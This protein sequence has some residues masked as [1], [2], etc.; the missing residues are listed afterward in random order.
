MRS[1]TATDGAA[2]VP[3]WGVPAPSIAGRRGCRSLS[4]ATILSRRRPERIDTCFQG[5]SGSPSFTVFSAR[6]GCITHPATRQFAGDK[7]CCIEKG[8]I[9]DHTR[10]SCLVVSEFSSAPVWMLDTSHCRIN[11]DPN[12]HFLYFYLLSTLHSIWVWES[13]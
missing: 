7:W 8:M 5:H 2:I 11:I 9:N 4:L 13:S 3:C 6:K 1:V 12:C 10:L